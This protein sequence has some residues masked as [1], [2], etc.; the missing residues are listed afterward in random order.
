MR[1]MNG[2][3]TNYQRASKRREKK[4]AKQQAATM[5]STGLHELD[6]GVM[7]SS[8]L[9]CAAVNVHSLRS[10]RGDPCTDRCPVPGMM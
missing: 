4:D 7:G 8:L 10:H 5:G 3:G 9:C 6:P 2:L 1:A